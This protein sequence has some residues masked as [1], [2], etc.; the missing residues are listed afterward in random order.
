MN[1]IPQFGTSWNEWWQVMQNTP[2]QRHFE[3]ITACAVAISCIAS[4]QKYLLEDVLSLGRQCSYFAS[5]RSPI[6]HRSLLFPSSFVL[7]LVLW[8]THGYSA[9]GVRLSFLDVEGQPIEA[10]TYGK[11]EI[12]KAPSRP[13]VADSLP[14][15]LQ[16]ALAALEAKDYTLEFTVLQPSL[17]H[18]DTMP[19]ILCSGVAVCHR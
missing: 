11:L 1:E 7:F 5:T 3:A 12:C 10:C 8:T 9:A 13:K 2:V 15:D 18:I 16:L 17:A 4:W 19:S 6:L 14:A